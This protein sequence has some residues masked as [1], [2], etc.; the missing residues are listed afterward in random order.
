VRTTIK[1]AN[2]EELFPASATVENILSVYFFNFTFVSFRTPLLHTRRVAN[3]LLSDVEIHLCH[4][5]RLLLWLTF[6]GSDI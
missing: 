6:A 4:L 3:T 1:D 2:A 5:N